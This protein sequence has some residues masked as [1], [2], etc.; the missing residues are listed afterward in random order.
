MKATLIPL[1]VCILCATSAFSG[2]LRPAAQPLNAAEYFVATN[3]CDAAD[4]SAERPWRTIQRAASVAGPGDTIT[5]RGG[6]YREWVK[7]ANAGTESA[8]VVYRAASGEKVV[9]TGADPVRGWK[10]R[11]DGLWEAHVAYD[12]FGGLNPFTDFIAGRWFEPRGKSISAQGFCR[13]AS[14]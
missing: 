4:G 1:S 8:P 3:G 2:A 10:K 5:I 14:R 9:V 7:P 6:V 11:A 12:T 13:T